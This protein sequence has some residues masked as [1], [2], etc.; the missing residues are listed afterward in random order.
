MYWDTRTQIN[1]ELNGV[2]FTDMGSI[3]IQSNVIKSGLQRAL[4]FQ[5]YTRGKSGSN[6]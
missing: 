4:I 2:E 6:L 3:Y 5:Q 1:L